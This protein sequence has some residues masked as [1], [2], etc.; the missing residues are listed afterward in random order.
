MT[1][2]FQSYFLRRANCPGSTPGPRINKMSENNSTQ[3][4][5]AKERIS[6]FHDKYYKHLLII[7]L[8]I[9]ILSI[10][11]MSTFYINNGDFIHKDISLTGGTTIT[12]FSEINADELRTALSS[13]LESL[14]VREISDF[15]TGEQKAVVIETKTESAEAKKI[16]EDY[17]GFSLDKKNSSIEFTGAVL[18]RGFFN[19]LL[20]AVI[21][22]FSLMGWVIFLI[23]GK[24]AKIKMLT[25]ALVLINTF[26]SF[27][28]FNQSIAIISSLVVLFFTLGVYFFYSIPSIAI[29]LSA[30]ADIF[31]TLVVLNLFGMQMSTAGI[32][33]LLMLIGYSVDTDILLTNKV[34]KNREESLNKNIFSSFKTGITMTLTAILSIS[35][36]LLIVSSFSAVLTKIFAVILIGL[37]FDI[38]NTWITNVSIIKWYV[39]KKGY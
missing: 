16:L 31:M 30:F 4:T 3:K 2:A 29:I 12:I 27:G 6:R 14:S 8:L 21:I 15:I 19:Q 18:S 17:L 33:A 37:G 32:V 22:A 26:L 1:F 13:K 25:G 7:P 10:I 34:L 36:A 38:I 35:V 5:T 28:V 20:L 9:F 39:L 23:F 11:Y 24:S